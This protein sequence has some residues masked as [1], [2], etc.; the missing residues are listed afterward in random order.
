MR[1]R[2]DTRTQILDATL[3]LIAAGGIDA[4]RYREVAERAG[5]PLGS[6]SY[7]YPARE[8]LLA[9]AFR[10][11]FATNRE[12]LRTVGARFPRRRKADI[13]AFLRE[14][15][16]IDFADATRRMFAEYELIQYAGRVPELAAELAEWDRA[17]AAELAVMLELFAVAHAESVARTLMEMVRGFQLVNLGR[18]LRQIG[19]ALDDFERRVLF[20]LTPR[21]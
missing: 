13:A 21:T 11:Y 1:D 19:A 16:R 2:P 15:I 10:S 3:A 5:V 9:A 6:V 14:L 18:T 12:F 8:A 4:V 17:M 20:V 7:H